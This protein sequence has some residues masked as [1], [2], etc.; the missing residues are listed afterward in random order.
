MSLTRICG[1]L[2]NYC[3]L[4]IA[5]ICYPRPSVPPSAYYDYYSYGNKSYYKARL[6]KVIVDI[7]LIDTIFSDYIS[8]KVDLRLIP[9]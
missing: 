1:S 3:L 8:N 2:N 6:V 7:A 9:Y 4:S 5:L